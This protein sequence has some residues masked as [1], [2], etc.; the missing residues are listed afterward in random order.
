MILETTL[1]KGEC[2]CGCGEPTPIAKHSNSARGHVKGQ[3]MNFIRGHQQRDSSLMRPF[4]RE[5]DGTPTP[6]FNSWNSMIARCYNPESNRFYRYGKRGICVCDRWLGEKG[7][8]NF[9]T[10]MGFKPEPKRLYSID[11]RKNTDDYAP[12]NCFWNI[13][14][15]ETGQIKRR[16]PFKQPLRRKD[17]NTEQVL[18]LY[19]DK[20]MSMPEVSKALKISIPTVSR[21]IEMSGRKA[22]PIG[23]N[24]FTGVITTR[25]ARLRRFAERGFTVPRIA[26]LLQISTQ[27]VRSYGRKHNINF[28]SARIGRPRKLHGAA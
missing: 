27:S 7:F 26:A 5:E 21:R 22:R 17:V 20:R 12:E 24:Q 6:E 16:D 14:P 8:V 28:Q 9:L 10:D 23:I 11:R 19:F 3:P 25:G 15:G 13:M 1:P 4:R 2:Q 18:H